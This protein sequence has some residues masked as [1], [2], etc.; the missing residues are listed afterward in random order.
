MDDQILE[1]LEERLGRLHAWE[2]LRIENEHQQK[3]FG[4]GIN[5]FHPENWYS[6][7][8]FIRYSLMLL[9]L[10]DRGRR[11]ARNIRVQNNTLSI[12]GLPEVF[13]GFTVL[14]ISDLHVDMA[15]DAGDA[16]IRSVQDLQYDLCVL[17]GD[18]RART[19]GPFEAT[20]QGMEKIRSRLKD[21][22]YGVLGNHDSIR[23]VPGLEAMGIRM[24]LNESATIEREGAV[25]HLSGIDDAHYYRVDDITKA[26]QEV[27][28][29]GISILLSHTPEIYRQAATAQFNVLLCGHTHGGQICLPGGYPLT[30]DARCPRTIGAGTWN[31]GDMIGYTS[32][33][34]GTSIVNARLNCP[35]EVTLHCLTRA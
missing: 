21:P 10:Y 7:H 28:R 18:Y 29:D 14:H 17:T 34:S 13:D 3:I 35:P 4:N 20:L 5:F 9:G 26:A 23:M 8:A 25:L 12:P 33:G 2:R 32:V 11:N 24:L 6:F 30:L 15:V 19:S 22:V 1:Q 31:Y 16:L 27:P